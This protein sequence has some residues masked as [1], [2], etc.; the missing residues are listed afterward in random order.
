MKKF[1]VTKYITINATNEAH[2]L[3]KDYGA[4]ANSYEEIYV[5]LSNIAKQFP[6]EAYYEL[7]LIHPDR[8]MILDAEAKRIADAKKKKQPQTSQKFSGADGKEFKCG[9]EKLSGTDGETVAPKAAGTT[10]AGF[11]LDWAKVKEKV[12]P[13]NVVVVTLLAI[14]FTLVFKNL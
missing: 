2:Q 12:T 1:P 14:G 3:I 8:K 7:G 9:D 13:T 4:D 5:H 10:L 11:N 6:E